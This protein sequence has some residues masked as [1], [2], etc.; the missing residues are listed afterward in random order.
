MER[1]IMN[2]KNIIR[3]AATG[4]IC[5]S[6][7][8]VTGCGETKGKREIYYDDKEN[9]EETVNTTEE[10]FEEKSVYIQISGAVKNPG[11]YEVKS[12]SRIFEVMDLSGGYTE[13]AATDVVNLARPVKDEMQ[14]YIPTKKEVEMSN[15]D[16]FWENYQMPEEEKE[17]S[18]GRVNLNTATKEE[19]MSLPGIGESKAE[20]ILDY[21]E[22]NGGFGDISDIMKISGIKEAAFEKIKELIV[23]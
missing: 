17:N 6:A 20:A 22:K 2:K 9:T 13:E 11:V 21:R 5:V 16:Y 15:Q 3:I 23:V 12:G 4:L 7:L 18:D 19:L 10:T 8:F 1:L 14:I